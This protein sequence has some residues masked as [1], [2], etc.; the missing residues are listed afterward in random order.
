MTK[1]SDGRPSRFDAAVRP[2]VLALRSFTLHARRLHQAS[3]LLS[4]Q[5]LGELPTDARIDVGLER[6]FI[7]GRPVKLAG[8]HMLLEKLL[9]QLLNRQ[10]PG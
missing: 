2:P 5:P 10:P 1:D 4:G 7:L 6:H 9:R 3:Y 8:I